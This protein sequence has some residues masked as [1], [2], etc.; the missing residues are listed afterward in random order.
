MDLIVTAEVVWYILPVLSDVFG[1]F[2]RLL[3]Q[4][5]NLVL[6]QCFYPPGEQ[7][8]G[9]EMVSCADD[10]LKYLA[11][12]GLLVDWKISIMNQKDSQTWICRA[13]LTHGK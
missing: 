1:E 12:A 10:L 6:K 7:Q 13:A 5:G 8:C 4:N 11:R 3:T 9:K 2:A